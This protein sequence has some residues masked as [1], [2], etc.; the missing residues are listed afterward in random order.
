MIDIYKNWG[1]KFGTLNPDDL[2]DIFHARR[3]MFRHLIPGPIR[4]RIAGTKT[5]K[6][7]VFF[8]GKPNCPILDPLVPYTCPNNGGDVYVMKFNN[9]LSRLDLLKFMQSDTE[10]D[11]HPL[12]IHDILPEQRHPLG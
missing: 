2:N 12:T 3:A 6:G 4:V 9:K 11:R 1:G 7:V 5:A 10:G 8:V